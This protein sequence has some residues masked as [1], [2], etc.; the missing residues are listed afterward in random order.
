MAHNTKKTM[1]VEVPEH[2][3]SYYLNS[4]RILRKKGGRRTLRKRPKMPPSYGMRPY[5]DDGGVLIWQTHREQRL[6]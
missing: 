2:E 3:N 4:Y 1:Q 6:L 5:K